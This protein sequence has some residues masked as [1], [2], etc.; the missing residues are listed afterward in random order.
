MGKLAQIALYTLVIVFGVEANPQPAG[1]AAGQAIRFDEVSG[2]AGLRVRHH[3]RMFQ[4]KAGDVL[5]M[6]TSGGAAVAVGDYDN[7]GFEDIFVTD[8]DTG[9]PNHLFHNN[10]DMTFTDVAV[11]AGVA[12]GNDPL[13]VVSD[14]LWFDYDNDGKQDLLIARFGTPI[15]YHNEGGGK[16]R[17]V[18]ASS[19]LNKF[20]NTIAVIAFDYDNDGYLD[21]MFG[22]YFKPMNLLDL[23]DPHVLPNNL[24]NATNG[25]GV[26]LWHNTGKGSF[27]EVTQKAGFGKITGWALDIGHGDLNN[28]GLQDV[29]IACDYGTDH[30][31]FN[32]GDGTFREVTETATGWDTK[33]GMNVDIADYDNDGWLDVYVTNITDE[34]MKECNMLWHNNGDGTFSDVSKETG[35]CDTGWGWAAKFADLD[36]DGWLDLFV[37]NGL[38]SAG[39]ESYVPLLLPLLTAPG[40]DLTDVNNWPKIGNRTWSGYQKKKLFHNLRNGTFAETSVQSG[41]DNDLDGRGIAVGDFDNDGRL[42]MV[43]TNADQPLLLY[44]NVSEKAGNWVELKLTGGKSNRDAIGARVR[45]E[46]RG[47]A[48]IREVDGGNGYAGQS[49]RRIHFGLGSA[50]KIDCLEIRWPGG[51]RETFNV[52]INR[53]T[54]VEEGKGVPVR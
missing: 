23:K 17:D 52:P 30:I 44:H 28:D 42:D 4:G 51:R 11:K 22:N 27:E 14:A 21:L 46:A 33:K 31:F 13:S 29:Y 38:R 18:S 45:M 16:F 1:G 47:L 48:Q 12:G 2:K 34:Y 7:D 15:L 10:G 50:D 36:N 39:N 9:K 32:N 26:T 19:G 8:S 43:Q 49:S 53:V 40:L 35:T 37:V 6:F 54:T 20:G 41:V 25:G 5:H 24:D 3:T